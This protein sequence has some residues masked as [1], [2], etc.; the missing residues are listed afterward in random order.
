MLKSNFLQ[1]ST[2]PVDN[3]DTI[4]PNHSQPKVAV[5]MTNGGTLT[6]EGKTSSIRRQSDALD[7]K[8]QMARAESVDY[9]MLRE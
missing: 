4:I 6:E 2:S 7:W 9:G 1:V 5:E 8:W 3:T